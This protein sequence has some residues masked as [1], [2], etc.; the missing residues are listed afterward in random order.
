MEN[1]DN[2][3]TSNENSGLSDYELEMD[4]LVT[5]IRN[6]PSDLICIGKIRRFVEAHGKNVNARNK[7]EVCDCEVPTYRLTQTGIR[8]FRCNG[9]KK[10]TGNCV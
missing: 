3:I 8:C 7:R 1:I 4:N 6:E 10:Q 2:E 5:E 9:L